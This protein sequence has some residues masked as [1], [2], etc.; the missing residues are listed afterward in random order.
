MEQEKNKNIVIALLVVVIVLLLALVILLATGTISFKSNELNNNQNSSNTEYEKDIQNELGKNDTFSTSTNSGVVEIIG[1]PETKELID[2]MGDGKH[3]NYV[4]FHIIES[5]STEFKNYIKSLEGN[6]YVLE[7]AIGIGCNSDGK[8]TY[9]N[10]SDEY[11]DMEYEIS[12]EDSSKILNAT[13]NNP[14]RLKLERL[15][16]SSGKGAPICYSHITKVEI[17]E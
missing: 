5:K 15:V 10:S 4:Y 12:K 16:Y 8:I 7:D 3:Y 14:I 2:E 13:E 1:Y 6:S 11:G 17:V 9:Y